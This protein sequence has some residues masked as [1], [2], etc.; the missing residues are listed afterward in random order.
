MKKI[1]LGELLTKYE[2]SKHAK[3]EAQVQRRVTLNMKDF[4]QYQGSNLDFRKSFQQTATNLEGQGLIKIEWVPYEKN[5]LIKALHLVLDRVEEAYIAIGRK[6][7]FDT[8]GELENLLAGLN[9]NNIWAKNFIHDCL[10][11]LGSKLKYPAQLP[12]EPE[13]LKMLLDT[14]VGLEAKGPEEMLERIFSKRYLGHSKAFEKHVRRRLVGLLG[15]YYKD[16]D[17]EEEALLAE[18]GLVRATSEVLI[19][20]PLSLRL[21]QENLDL[22]PFYYGLSLGYET[23][24]E[25]EILGAGCRR[26]ISIENKATFREILR[27]GLDETTLLICLG[28]FAGPVKRKFLNKLY[29]YLGDT[30]NYYHWGDL[31]YGG[32]L[33]FNH[34]RSCFPGLQPLLM[35]KGTYETFMYL[36]EDYNDTYRQKL[37]ALLNEDKFDCFHDVILSMLKNGL[38]L[39]QEAV[40]TTGI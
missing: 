5:N 1:I 28:G 39:E 15:R 27:K 19:R 7:K 32:L 20:G 11:E 10:L 35:D 37:Q 21:K 34:L 31:D 8:L 2:K 9:L 36:G 40:P 33:I 29:I 23:I 22:K 4:P 26:L 6:P 16:M 13:K 14:L 25:S 12:H 3:G 18:V 30:V 24:N 38:T 17:L